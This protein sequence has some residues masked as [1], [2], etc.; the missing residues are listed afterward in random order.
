MAF[1][2]W[3]NIWIEKQ[4]LE[5]LSAHV[6]RQ[7]PDNVPTPPYTLA[8]PKPI[9]APTPGKSSAKGKQSASKASQATVNKPSGRRLPVPPEPH[10][11]LASRV[12]AYSPALPTGVLIETVKAG[13]NAQE[14]A[15]AGAG[16]ATGGAQKGKRKVVRVRA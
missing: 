1:S 6:Q 15:G 12:S 16:T 5:V 4:L 11:S 7:K 8:P 14:T 13:M 9:T 3:L 2:G 10:P